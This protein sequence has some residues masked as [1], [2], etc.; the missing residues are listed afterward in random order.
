MGKVY[1]G[2][3]ANL[4]RSVAV[5]VMSP[6]L[7]A[8]PRMVERFRT[9][10]RAASA[11]NHPNCV[12]VYDFGETQ[13]GRP[14][15]VMEL[16][17]GEDL[18]SL[19]DRGREPPMARVLDI[20]LQV[21]SALEEAHAMGIVHRDLKPANVV[22]LPQR[23]GGELVK[24]VDFGL[25][26]L[27]TSESSGQGMV[28]GTP[29]YIAPEQAMAKGTDARTDLYACGIM[30]YEMIAGRR[31][32]EA[33]DPNAL[34]R[35]HAF[36]APEPLARLAPERAAFGLDRWSIAPSRRSPPS[37]T[38][39]R[40]SSPTRSARSWRTVRA[41][42]GSPTLAPGSALRAAPVRAAATR[43]SSRRASAESAAPCSRTR[44]RARCARPRRP[45]TRS[46]RPRL[47]RARRRRCRRPPPSVPHERR[48]R[49]GEDRRRLALRE[50]RSRRPH[51]DPA[52]AAAPRGRRLVRPAA[53]RERGRAARAAHDP[54]GDR[55]SGGLGRHVE[56]DGLP[57]ADRRHAHEARRAARCGGRA[58]AR[59]RARP[60]RPR[61][62]GARRSHPRRRDL[63]LQAGRRA[64]S[65]PAT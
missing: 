1:R 46:P 24:V 53:R 42:R 3:Q 65:H 4:G 26:K 34:L 39:R 50:G 51:D 17:K 35:L 58:A 62:R 8:N 54:V 30:L 49:S 28:L 18:E 33:D 32:F 41:R 43:C 16:L 21:L 63:Q 14:Y 57:R 5:K 15:M 37:A 61:S 29:E 64:W 11:L 27:R 13:D 56:R 48:E 19:L 44:L 40:P 7:V 6:G 31:P 36:Q 22:V 55:R 2:E 25:A 59:D 20:V 38:R 45:P 9:E 10:A 12:R 23:G 47:L 52:R 60:A